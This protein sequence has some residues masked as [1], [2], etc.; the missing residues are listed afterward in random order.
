MKWVSSSSSPKSHFNNHFLFRETKTWH[1]VIS[2]SHIC[3]PLNLILD[4]TL[5]LNISQLWHSNI[6]S[7]RHR[8]AWVIAPPPGQEKHNPQ[9]PPDNVWWQ[10]AVQLIREVGDQR[11]TM[12]WHFTADSVQLV[13]T[14]QPLLVA[15]GGK[16]REGGE[17]R[18][19]WSE[20]TEG[21]NDPAW[22]LWWCCWVMISPLLC[23]FSDAVIEQ[24]ISVTTYFITT[25]LT[26][27]KR[28][29]MDKYTWSTCNIVALSLE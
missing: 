6:W 11:V 27:T 5:Q 28:S 8:Y 23:Q 21:G 2:A 18:G 25:M 20:I 7:T 9:P 19:R 12:W 4:Y 16:R 24:D 10:P 1:T 26:N 15:G 17:R 22:W 29:L 13:H 3:L 14:R